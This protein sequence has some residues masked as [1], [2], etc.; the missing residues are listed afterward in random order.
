MVKLLKT[1]YKEGDRGWKIT[2]YTSQAISV[3][4]ILTSFFIPPVAVID[5]SIFLAIGELA[6]F[7]MLYAFYMIV[8]SGRKASIQKGETTI[9][10]NSDETING[11]DN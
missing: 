3:L 9:S 4:L 8:M 11:S 7:P 1:W 5:A 2:F 10:V 6:F